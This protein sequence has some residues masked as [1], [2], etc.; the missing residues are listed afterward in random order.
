[1]PHGTMATM[2]SSAAASWLVVKPGQTRAS[3]SVLKARPYL[4]NLIDVLKL[5]GLGFR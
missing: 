4:Y 1:M 3:S 5:I 2:G